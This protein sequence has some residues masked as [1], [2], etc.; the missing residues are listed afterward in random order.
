MKGKIDENGFFECI[1]CESARNNTRTRCRNLSIENDMDPKLHNLPA[2]L[3]PLNDIEQI[4]ISRAN[5]MM[6]VFKLSKGHVR[7]KGNILNME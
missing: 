2:N 7:H 3:P 5:T 6:K 4:M 1:S